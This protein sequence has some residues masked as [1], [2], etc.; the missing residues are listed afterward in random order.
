[1]HAKLDFGIRGIWNPTIPDRGLVLEG[2]SVTA[3]N[4]FDIQRAGTSIL[5]VSTSGDLNINRINL[6]NG[7][8]GAESIT[9]GGGQTGIHSGGSGTIGISGFYGIAV[10]V[11]GQSPLTYLGWTNVGGGV[12]SGSFVGTDTLFLGFNTGRD[13][14]LIRDA[15]GIIAQRN[16]TSAQ[17][18]RLYNTYTDASNYERLS[19]DWQTTANVFRIT[20]EA[21]GTGTVRNIAFMGG[22]VGIGLTAPAQALQVV[23]NIGLGTQNVM[24]S[25]ENAAYNGTSQILFST[26]TFN[27]GTSIVLN[28]LH[29][30]GTA[31]YNALQFAT[32]NGGDAT[33]VAG[34]YG[35]IKGIT[36]TDTNPSPY[37]GDMAFSVGQVAYSYG[38]ISNFLETMRISANTHGV[39]IGTGYAGTY[40]PPTDGLLVKG[41]VGIGATS[42]TR[43]L[44]VVANTSQEYAA[45]IT[46]QNNSGSWR[47]ALLSLFP[48][49]SNGQNGA[50]FYGGKALNTYEGFGIN[51]NH[52]SPS[53][54]N[55]YVS[56]N[57]Y[58]LDN[59]LTFNA[60]GLVG[61]GT[62]TP[63]NLLNIYSGGGFDKGITITNLGSGSSDTAAIKL[64]NS[65]YYTTLF[66]GTA[67]HPSVPSATGFYTNAANGFVIFPNAK[68]AFRAKDTVSYFY[69][70][71][72]AGSVG[73]GTNSPSFKLHVSGANSGYIASAVENTNANGY[74]QFRFITGSTVG[75]LQVYGTGFGAVGVYLP[76]SVAYSTAASNGVIFSNED[77]SGPMSFVTGGYAAN[78][79][80]MRIAANGNV[81]IA[82]TSPSGL[83]HITSTNSTYNANNIFLKLQAA[84]GNVMTFFSGGSDGAVGATV[85]GVTRF[86]FGGAANSGVEIPTTN[87]IWFVNPGVAGYSGILQD[88]TSPEAVAI[89]HDTTSQEF[90]VYDTFTD[91]SNYRRITSKFSGGVG[92]VV[93]EGAGTGATVSMRVGTVGQ[94]DLN[95]LVNNADRWWIVGNTSYSFLA[96]VDNSYDIGAAGNYRPKTL[97]LGTSL[98]VGNSTVNATLNSTSL[99]VTNLTLAGN[100]T[101]SGSLTT[102]DT[103][104]LSVMD[105]MIIVADQLAS[106]NTFLDNVDAGWYIKTGNTSVNYYSGIVRQASLST[107][108]NPVLR[109]FNSNVAP[110][111]T[112]IDSGSTTG[113]LMA[114]LSSGALVSNATA[115]VITANSTVNVAVTANV[116]GADTVKVGN[117]TVN[118]AINS[119][120]IAINGSVGSSGQ[121][122]TSNGTVTSWQT[123][124]APA[125]VNTAAAFAWTNSHS[126][127]AASTVTVGNSTVN[128]VLTSTTVTIGNTTVNT[129]ISA[130]T[131]SMMNLALAGW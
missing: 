64:E 63:N 97:Y 94:N 23:G 2:G 115:V 58:G 114:Y 7:S 127:D 100:L 24:K 67:S 131:Q 84:S 32:C 57:F 128:V 47:G 75:A 13:T 42:P 104:N 55:N 59:I 34:I 46:N 111:A 17:A 25:R 129:V 86:Y 62:T 14:F 54:A 88:S 112:T 9:F 39:V 41:I 122:L 6:S 73:I 72:D 71:G 56:F 51:Y 35:E 105:N 96:G 82:T 66:T 107:N 68:R 118:V 69:G 29:G 28:S 43:K 48:N 130:A 3:T 20:S 87:K 99:S 76:A 113:T 18:L 22:N 92:Y 95:F 109:V 31:G 90:R 110:G 5:S 119:T 60:S 27:C 40:V 30:S 126:W 21:A 33:Q 108:T 15:A 89:R 101:V 10:H 81:G 117:S 65:S 53:N 78:N 4:L 11:N 61:I 77:A 103:I 12:P 45:S 85:G 38:A 121:V 16:S 123:P 102:I 36:G 124:S 116:V 50:I 91:G 19:L 79:E 49:L 98:V 1:M 125:G 106:T 74:A 93:T 52:V 83:L 120:A 37:G 80:R 44:E 70:D 8:S 26:N